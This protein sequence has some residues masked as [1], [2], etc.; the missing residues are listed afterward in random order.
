M[1]KLENLKLKLTELRQIKVKGSVIRSRATNLVEG[2]KP[3]KY[4]WFLETHNYLSEIIPKLEKADGRTITDQHDIL[5]E[6]EL[7]Y[8]K[9]HSN[10]DDPVA[11]INIKEYLKDVYVQKLTQNES[12]QL[13]GNLTLPE[14][15][16]ALH[17][18]KNNKSPGTDVYSCEFFK[19]FWNKIGTFVMR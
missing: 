16:K 5:K 14:L 12:N 19:V 8:K 7:F 18:M 1:E 6:S 13:E 2:E 17:N 15:T 11:E 4:F 3:T 9:L 10:K